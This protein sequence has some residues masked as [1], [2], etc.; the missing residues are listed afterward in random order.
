M[1]DCR[2]NVQPQGAVVLL[3]CCCCEQTALTQVSQWLVLHMTRTVRQLPTDTFEFAKAYV[4]V[5]D[6]ASGAPPLKPIHSLCT[7]NKRSSGEHRG[8]S[9][10]SSKGFL[11]FQTARRSGGRSYAQLFRK[12]KASQWRTPI[13]MASL[14][15]PMACRPYGPPCNCDQGLVL[16]PMLTTLEQTGLLQGQEAPSEAPSLTIEVSAL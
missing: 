6:C 7:S 16:A 5:Y 4:R 10:S 12:H 14:K 13:Y 11:K 8:R 3:L 2:H 1:L 15:V 9:W